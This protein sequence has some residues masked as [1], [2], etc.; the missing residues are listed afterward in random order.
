[1]QSSLSKHAIAI[2]HFAP[3]QIC[4]LGQSTSLVQVESSHRLLTQVES[5]EQSSEILQLPHWPLSQ[6]GI[7]LAFGPKAIGIIAVEQSAEVEHE[8]TAV[9]VP[10]EPGTNPTHFAFCP[11]MRSEK[12]D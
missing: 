12:Q 3:S 9:Q 11:Q 6:S 7:W 10:G 2:L 8:L 4:I 1:L 5:R